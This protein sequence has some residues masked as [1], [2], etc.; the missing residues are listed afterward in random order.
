MAFHIIKFV[1]SFYESCSKVSLVYIGNISK[2]IRQIQNITS[3]LLTHHHESELKALFHRFPV[4]LVRQIREP[5]IPRSLRVC[6][7][8]L[9]ITREQN[10]RWRRS[11]K[12]S[13]YTALKNTRSS[14]NHFFAHQLHIKPKPCATSTRQLSFPYLQFFSLR[15][16]ELEPNLQK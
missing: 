9:L 14:Q 1:F 12:K 16:F 3:M 15:H 13:Y 5:H 4:Y 7:L 8:S 11:F 10:N 6:K 2:F